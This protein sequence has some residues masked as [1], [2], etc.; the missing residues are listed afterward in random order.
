MHDF[1]H[2]FP[3][4]KNRIVQRRVRPLVFYLLQP[5]LQIPQPPKANPPQKFAQT[6][7]SRHFRD[8]F[9]WWG[10]R[11][12]NPRPLACEANALTS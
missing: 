4:W 2:P 8:G 11:G 6:A 1:L 10:W 3:I 5:L 9:G 12:S 7:K